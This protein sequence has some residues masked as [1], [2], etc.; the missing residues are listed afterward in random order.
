MRCVEKSEPDWQH[1]IDRA[2]KSKIQGELWRIVESQSQIATLSLVDSLEEQTILEE[3]LESNKPSKP[4]ATER[5][6]YLLATPFRYPPLKWG[7]RFGEKIEPGIF[8]GSLDV[9]TVLVEAAYYRFLF[10]SGMQQPYPGGSLV[11]QHEIFS[12][13]YCCHPGLKLQVKPFSSYRS[14]LAHPAKY[15]G[16][17][18]LGKLLRADN[19]IGFEFFSA[20]AVFNNDKQGINVALLYPSALVDRRPN[21]NQR[22][23]CETTDSV[24][25][26]RGESQLTEFPR[27]QFEID[28]GLPQPA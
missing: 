19:I 3:L 13:R 16:A 1:L 12:A 17:K 20:R 10:W 5:L 8:Y 11:T 22:W 23:V 9:E 6:H 4:A 26:F 27:S 21:N 25:R 2:P 24:V 28:G 14:V 15:A 18:K 7:S